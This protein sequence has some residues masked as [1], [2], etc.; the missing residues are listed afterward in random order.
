M[1]IDIDLAVW[2]R[3]ACEVARRNLTA[4]E[5]GGLPAKRRIPACHKR[6]AAPGRLIAAGSIPDAPASGAV[7][8]GVG[9]HAA[10]AWQ[11]FLRLLPAWRG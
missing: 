1:V 3:R 5:W 4:A 11:R 7:D 6:V 2:R 8:N 10:M 9:V